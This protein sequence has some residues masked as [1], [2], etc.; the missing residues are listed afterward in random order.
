MKITILPLILITTLFSCKKDDPIT[1][2]PDV[3]IELE[4][5]KI[6]KF[7]LDNMDSIYY[8]NSKMPVLD[9]KKEANTFF[10]FD[11]L[12][13]ASYDVNLNRYIDQWSFLTN[14]YT[15]LLEYFSGIRKTMGH[16]IRLFKTTADK[17]DLI[18][19]VEYVEPNSP[20]DIAGLVRGDIFYKIDDKILNT[21]NYSDL[22]ARESYK[23][24][25]GN[26]NY[27]YSITA[28]TPSINLSQVK[29]KENPIHLSKIIE[30]NGLKIGYLMYKSFNR[31]YND[32]L[33]TVFTEF[34]NQ[35][36]DDLVLDLR[37]NGGG[38]SAST[39]LLASMIAPLSHEGQVFVKR[40]YNETMIKYYLNKYPNDPD[41]L[42]SRLEQN[43]NNL[44]LDRLVVL[45]TYK[46]AS[47]S[48]MIIYGLS[49]HMNVYH[50]GE[51]TH[52]KYYGSIT[53]AD[54]DTHNW[55]LQPIV[56]R[57]EN[58]NNS[59]N[60]TIGLEPDLKR[61]DFLD[62]SEYFQ[63]GD[64]REDFLAQALYYL[65][66][67]LPK[68]SYLKSKPSPFIPINQEFKLDHP[69]TYDMQFEKLK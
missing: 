18:G 14:D 55:A 54:E 1:I 56:A 62:A 21:D 30:H 49:P 45:S 24:T 27:D 58:K 43:D 3:T 15:G 28:R 2:K 33:E 39:I 19:F 68:H 46:T 61:T 8:W 41:L 34:K 32:Q 20:A 5:Q 13:T 59:I 38:S 60:Y 66:G 26:L 17:N 63:L 7:V 11:K 6:N 29:L 57:S 65:T 47:A 31:E 53:I 4:T 12:L 10:L 35:E 40:V 36:I 51:Q 25:L 48:E 37:Y 22:L 64:P 52:G 9:Y 50:I 67:T 16:S 23:L 42:I 69:L 44:N